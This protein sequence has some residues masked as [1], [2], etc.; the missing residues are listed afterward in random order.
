[1][2]KKDIAIS[3]QNSNAP[4]DGK[5]TL[6]VNQDLTLRST[7]R[8]KKDVRSW[9][10]A[11]VYAES[12]YYPNHVRLFDLYTDILL[13]GHLS[14]IIN[15]RISSVKNK[16]LVFKKGED[17]ID[18]MDSLIQSKAFGDII[19]EMIWSK[20]FGIS[21][22]EF[23]PGPKLTFNS[24]PRKHI[25]MKTQKIM[26]EQW[27]IND[28]I[29]YPELKNIWVIGEP[30]DL[31]LLSICGF[32]ALLKKGAI[33]NWAEYIELYGSP[34]MIIKYKGY[35]LQEQKAGE[36]IINEAG[37]SMKLVIPE[38][39]GFDVKD[40]KSANGDGKL[41]E[42]FLERC[43]QEMSLAILGNSET[44][45]N[46]KHGT[47]AKSQV[48]SEEQKQ[49][50]KD[51]M[52]FTADLLNSDHF[53]DILASYGYPVEGGHFEYDGEIDI[54]FIKQKLAVDLPLI[55]AGL[56]VTKEY[57][58]GQYHIPEPQPG[59]PIVI[60]NATAD[61]D[62]DAAEDNPL[63]V[64]PKKAA[65]KKAKQAPEPPI[66]ASDVKAILSD[67]FANALI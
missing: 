57:L 36:R 66:T 52:D 3:T 45:T 44:S 34:I 39:M 47:G 67:F 59:E 55:Q 33:S 41:H 46:G 21:G 43:N 22:L 17:K 2:D 13:D 1:M 51:D 30:N 14:G 23:V 63:P 31:G 11:I 16:T 62:N 58:Y 28:G 7:L 64:K 9:R 50:I 32:Y 24:I 49:I 53:I 26:Y 56:P 38:E 40:G 54:D 5:K 19:K 4:I 29:F 48:H 18:E 27:D 25:S 37:N 35:G 42:T 65:P 60:L 15:K 10:N 12:V 6:M 8:D 20:M 61:P